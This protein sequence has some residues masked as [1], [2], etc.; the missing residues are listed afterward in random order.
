MLSCCSL[1]GR[2]KLPTFPSAAS[3]TP[4]KWSDINIST[5]RLLWHG[6]GPECP[7]R[8]R[9]NLSPNLRRHYPHCHLYPRQAAR[10][11]Q[12]SELRWAAMARPNVPGSSALGASNPTQPHPPPNPNITQQTKTHFGWRAARLPLSGLGPPDSS[13]CSTWLCCPVT[14]N[15]D[16][17]NRLCSPNGGSLFVRDAMWCLSRHHLSVT[18]LEILKKCLK[19]DLI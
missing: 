14:W 9:R 10:A 6:V 2:T 8:E 3:V 12:S 4:K 18:V 15:Q 17:V 1:N 11:A 5:V 7:S 13:Q 16:N 19:F